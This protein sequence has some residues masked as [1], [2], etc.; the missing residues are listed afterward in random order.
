MKLIYKKTC[1]VCGTEFESKN[2]FCSKSCACKYNGRQANKNGKLTNHNN[3]NTGRTYFKAKSDGWTCPECLLNFRTRR[4]LREH[5]IEQHNLISG[6]YVLENGKRKFIGVP[7]NKGQTKETN[8]SIA[9]YAQTYSDNI[10][11][12]KT[13]QSD[14][15]KCWTPERRKE[16]SERKKKLYAEHP[17]KHPNAKLAGNHNKMT[18]PE[19]LTYDW[20]K[21]HN[22]NPIH[23]WHFI[24]ENFNRYID[25]Y[26]EEKYLFIEIDGE[27]WHKDV[28]KDIDKDLDANFHGYDTLRIKP[29]Y[30]VIKQLEEYFN[31]IN[32]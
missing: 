16:Q 29:K 1:E 10:K 30:G 23:N 11:S 6:N 21:E 32:E 5:K 13:V 18:Y 22:Y 15:R 2:R 19:Q 8:K 17:E 14:H 3:H 28:Q 4:L 7:W 9:K 25:F 26:I 24:S 12:G 20:L 27:Y 31:N